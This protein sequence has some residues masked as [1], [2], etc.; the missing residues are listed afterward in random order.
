MPVVHH[1]SSTST[2]PTP[3]SN[4]KSVR[5]EAD[6]SIGIAAASSLHHTATQLSQNEKLL[7][8]THT[9]ITRLSSVTVSDSTTSRVYDR[10]LIFPSSPSRDN[11]EDDTNM[12]KD[13]LAEFLALPT[14][15]TEPSSPS[16]EDGGDI[17]DTKNFL[18]KILAL[19]SATSTTSDPKILKFLYKKMMKDVLVNYRQIEEIP[20]VLSASRLQMRH[21]K[22]GAPTYRSAAEL[23]GAQL[24]IVSG[25]QFENAVGPTCV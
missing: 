5:Y 15:K 1:D 25:A 19:P 14:S 22:S 9:E 6:T 20:S 8:L 10:P 3:T 16:A 4:S 2:L 7:S 23:S 12:Q 18:N 11:N 13:F 21:E 24:E 17:S